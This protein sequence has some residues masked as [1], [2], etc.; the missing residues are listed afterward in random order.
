MIDYMSRMFVP[1]KIDKIRVGNNYD[2]GYVLPT[3]SL[4]DC[5]IC[6]SY[7]LGGNITFENQVI[8]SGM[9]VIGFD[10]VLQEDSPAWASQKELISYKDLVDVVGIIGHNK[11]LLKVDVEGAEWGFIDSMDMRHFSE[12]IHTF[13]L[14]IHFYNKPSFIPVTVFDK[15]FES[16]YL[17]H[18]HANNHS[19]T[20]DDGVPH[21]IELT[22]INKSVSG[23][24]GIDNGTFPTPGLDF[25]CCPKGPDVMIPWLNNH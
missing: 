22:F 4:H 6:V 15:I 17:V 5:S 23:F 7:G 2:G 25:P 3:I 13:A 20:Y 1:R 8:K 11:I 10:I 19:Y 14:E 21:V 16:H 24:I 18:I 9:K 12:N